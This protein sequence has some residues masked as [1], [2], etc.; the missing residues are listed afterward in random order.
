VMHWI[1]TPLRPT[2]FRPWGFGE[3]RETNLLTAG[4]DTYWTL[5]VHGATRP[6]GSTA[7]SVSS[8]ISRCAPATT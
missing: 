2:T 5:A 7:G 3:S 1:V 8:R 4:G 6:I